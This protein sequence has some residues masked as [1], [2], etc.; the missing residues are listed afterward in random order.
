[1]ED[2]AA[3]FFHIYLPDI[4][5]SMLETIVDF[6]KNRE[7]HGSPV[8]YCATP[9]LSNPI[10]DCDIKFIGKKPMSEVVSLLMA[11]NYLNCEQ[12]LTRC[13]YTIARFIEKNT[14]S[15]IRRELD[16]KCDFTPEEWKDLMETF[17]LLLS[18]EDSKYDCENSSHLVYKDG[19][20][21]TLD[22][23]CYCEE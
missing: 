23:E 9:D 17:G 11:A 2:V 10:L 4:S 13:C 18:E 12:V 21:Y 6:F 20:Y 15:V 22:G 16:I 3:V 7:E 1:M 5:V 14:L 8:N 19:K